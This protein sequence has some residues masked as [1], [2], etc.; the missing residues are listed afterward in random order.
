MPQVRRAL[1]PR[2]AEVL[3]G[4]AEEGEHLVAVALGADEVGVVLMCA[5]EPVLVLA[6]AEEVVALLDERRARSGGRGTC[7]RPAPAPW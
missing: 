4:L 6:H 2:D 3:Q 5:D 7:R 1:G